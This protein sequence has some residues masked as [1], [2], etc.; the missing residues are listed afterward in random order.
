MSLDKKIA[1]VTGGSQ[2]IGRAIS[3]ALA[4]K[5]AIVVVNYHSNHSIA[6]KTTTEIRKK[7]RQSIS[8]KANVTIYKEVQEIVQEVKN[9]FGRIDILVN[10]AGIMEDAFLP[11]LKETA[12]HKVIDTNLCGVYNCTEAVKEIMISQRSGKIINITSLTGI[13][14]EAGRTNYA[15]SKAGVI[16]YTRAVANILSKYNIYVN[17]VAPGAIEAGLSRKVSLARV[18]WRYLK[19]IPLGRL[20]RAEEVAQTVVFL[21]SEM[22][23][24]IT[25]EVIK[26]SGGHVM[27]NF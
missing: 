15:T 9:R 27:Y 26:V 24:F 17:A 23:N 16:G 13:A 21:A 18:R 22:S 12:W 19:F 14:G 7:S 6:E 25:G 8:V 20:G 11:F 1:I 5:G 10:N 2:G 4:N 3:L